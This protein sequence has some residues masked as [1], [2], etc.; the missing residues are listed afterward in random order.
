MPLKLTAASSK[1]RSLSEVRSLTDR[2]ARC[3]LIRDGTQGPTDGEGT[4]AGVA[5]GANV[6]ITMLRSIR[7]DSQ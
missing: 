4:A 7:G 1:H 3:H 6:L 2:M 5:V